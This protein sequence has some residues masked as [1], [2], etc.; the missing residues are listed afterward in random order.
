MSGKLAIHLE[1]ILNLYLS[2]YT[3]QKYRWSKNLNIKKDSKLKCIWLFLQLIVGRV[4]KKQQ[5]NK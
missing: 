4:F 1:Q 2:P 3:T 5:K